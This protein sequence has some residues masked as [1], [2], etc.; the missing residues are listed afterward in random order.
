MTQ[1][2]QQRSEAA[3]SSRQQVKKLSRQESD[4]GGT[5]RSQGKKGEIPPDSRFLQKKTAQLFC[6]G[7]SQRGIGN[8]IEMHT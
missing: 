8:G 3:G 2:Q 4:Y 7:V 5:I 1:Q 6:L